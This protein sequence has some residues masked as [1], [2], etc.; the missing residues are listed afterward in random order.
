MSRIVFVFLS[1]FFVSTLGFSQIMNEEGE[2]IKK[3]KEKKIKKPKCD[4][5]DFSLFYVDFTSQRSFRSFED[6]SVYNSYAEWEQQTRDFNFG[7]SGGLMMDLAPNIQLDIGASYF[8]HGENYKYEDPDSLYSFRNRY[9]QLAIP[10][11]LKFVYGEDFQFY[12]GIGGMPSN[13]LSIRFTEA[14]RFPGSTEITEVEPVK[15]K[16]DFNSFNFYLLGS[17]G[18]NYYLRYIGFHLG[19]DYRYGLTNTYANTTTMIDH[20]MNAF[21]LSTGLILKI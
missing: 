15:L 10:F 5:C 17:V 3:K 12:A 1:F 8:G 13:I 4:T 2:T 6:N 19:F 7:V 21:V 20:K 11:R 16:N 18:I 9:M 14:Y